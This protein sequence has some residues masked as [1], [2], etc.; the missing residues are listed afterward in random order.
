ME[1]NKTKMKKQRLV[2]KALT[3]KFPPIKKKAKKVTKI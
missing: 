3:K 1:K 2:K